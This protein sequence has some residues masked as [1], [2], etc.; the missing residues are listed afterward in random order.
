MSTALNSIDVFQLAP[1]QENPKNVNNV[2]DGFNSYLHRLKS[3]LWCLLKV[4]APAFLYSY[5]NYLYLFHLV[6]LRSY[7]VSYTVS[8]KLS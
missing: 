4:F 7:N 8:S 2:F 6:G 5:L 3:S 1:F